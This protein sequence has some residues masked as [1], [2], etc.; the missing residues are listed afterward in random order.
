MQN[1]M[2]TFHIGWDSHYYLI[3]FARALPP[4]LPDRSLP[5]SPLFRLFRPEFVS[6]YSIP[7]CSDGFS[8]FISRDKNKSQHN[9]DLMF[10]I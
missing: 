4:V 10:A 3:D 8:G 1:H 7:L 2:E 6:A 5:G 9:S